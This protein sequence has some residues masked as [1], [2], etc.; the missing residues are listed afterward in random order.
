MAELLVKID[1]DELVEEIQRRALERGVSPEEEVR[2]ALNR[3]F[4]ERPPTLLPAAPKK[5]YTLADHI[6]KL[7]EVAPDIDFTPVRTRQESR[8]EP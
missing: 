5:D 1:S 7:A 8:F 3:T 6:M 4:L 2:G